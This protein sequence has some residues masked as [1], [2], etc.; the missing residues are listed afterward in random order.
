MW[1]PM[2]ASM[3]RMAITMMMIMVGMAL[4]FTMGS[5]TQIIRPTMHGEDATTMAVLITIEI[6]IMMDIT[7]D[8]IMAEAT[9]EGT[10]GT[11]NLKIA[12]GV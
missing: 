5:I 10:E 8:M 11:T 6:D 7:T 9:M 4:D 2:L 3:S 12:L 1:V